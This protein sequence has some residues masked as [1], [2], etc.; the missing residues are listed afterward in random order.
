MSNALKFTDAGGTVT[1]YA[2]FVP[3]VEPGKTLPRVDDEADGT[4]AGPPTLQQRLLRGAGIVLH[5]LF[6]VDDDSINGDAEGGGPRR[7][8][9]AYDTIRV[10]DGAFDEAGVD[11]T[12]AAVV[13]G[14][15]RITVQVRYK[16]AA[17]LHRDHSY[18]TC[19]CVVM[20]DDGVGISRAN[21][22][23]LFKEVVQFSPE[24][25][26]AG[27]GSGYGLCLVKGI[28]DLHGGGVAAASDGL[29]RGAT[30]TVELPMERPL[31]MHARQVATSSRTRA[32]RGTPLH[33][34]SLHV[35][36]R[37]GAANTRGRH[38]SRLL[39][40]SRGGEPG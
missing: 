4:G 18:T 27:G 19:Y 8:P 10:R 7:V 23:R 17:L 3:G 11:L 26:R 38:C 37:A 32:L 34:R 25:L 33:I 16:T 6:G 13:V 35:T 31:G 12:E 36:A 30:F 15:L 14:T 2:A 28:V 39:G 5:H 21:L 29:G 20:Q 9:S 1:V 40:P 22:G 24:R